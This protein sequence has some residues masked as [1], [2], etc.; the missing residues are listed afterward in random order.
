MSA[1][2]PWTASLV[3]VAALAG[4][5]SDGSEPLAG[6][7]RTI[8]E[9]A[10]SQP[11]DL[12]ALRASDTDP[13]VVEWIDRR[14]GTIRSVDLD[15]PDEIVVLASIDV[16]MDGEQ[17]GLLGQTTV[18]GI[19]Y[20]AWTDPE[21][22]RL[23]VGALTDATPAG[24]DRI[25]WDAGGTASGAV[26][27]HLDATA[28][29]MI[30]LGIGQL[31]DWARDHGSGAMLRLD[32]LGPADQEPVVVSDGYINPFAFAV[33]GDRLWIADNAVGDDTERTGIVDLATGSN[34][35]DRGDLVATGEDPR[36][37]SAVV[38]LAD[39]TIGVCGFLD[40]ELR[41]W[42]PDPSGYGASIGPCLA[43]AAV[44]RDGT[45]VTATADALVA[46][47]P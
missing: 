37:P 12:I 45:I 3:V 25:V 21:T 31:T 4:C 20:A 10:D 39:G 35:V 44:L 26:G 9:F 14:A 18:E 2:R 16:G 24:V 5:S 19:R 46:I 40:G 47:A 8:V 7:V 29:G 41:L 11:G 13:T 38:A 36:A 42:S 30:M 33:Q 1:L 34:R 43:G 23:I 32:P 22:N 28:N 17:R 27:G 15:D 6:D